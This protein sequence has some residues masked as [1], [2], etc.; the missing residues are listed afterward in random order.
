MEDV[1]ETR[2]MKRK[3]KET[4]EHELGNINKGTETQEKKET[5]REGRVYRVGMN[6]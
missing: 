5:R 2:R 6:K 4:S 1:R 3:N